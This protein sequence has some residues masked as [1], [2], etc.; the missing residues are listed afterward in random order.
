METKDEWD[1]RESAESVSKFR[2][3]VYRIEIAA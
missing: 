1:L 3:V 2:T